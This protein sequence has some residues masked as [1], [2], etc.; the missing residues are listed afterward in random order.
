MAL[1]KRSGLNAWAATTAATLAA[2]VEE[3]DYGAVA[4]RWSIR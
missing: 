3:N 1:G 4:G 2:V